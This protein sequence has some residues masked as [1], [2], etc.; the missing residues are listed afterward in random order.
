MIGT[1]SQG[2]GRSRSRVC[3]AALRRPEREFCSI[4]IGERVSL[5]AEQAPSQDSA[6]VLWV[7]TQDLLSI[8]MIW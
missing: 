5:P 7:M 8:C 4:V 3:G 2:L 6:Q 1:V